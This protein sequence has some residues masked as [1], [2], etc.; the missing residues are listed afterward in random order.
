MLTFSSLMHE[1]FIG[2]RE[3]NFSLLRIDVPGKKKGLEVE[4]EGM[5]NRDSKSNF[6]CDWNWYHYEMMIIKILTQTSPRQHP[7]QPCLGSHIESNFF[8]SSQCMLM[9]KE[10]GVGLKKVH[11]V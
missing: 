8:M 7:T 9:P 1:Y 10:K 3:W 6:Y 5:A 11:G 4:S 2:L